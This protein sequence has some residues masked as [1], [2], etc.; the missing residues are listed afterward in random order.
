MTEIILM[1]IPLSL[2][3]QKGRAVDETNGTDEE[4]T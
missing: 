3:R 2:I 4:Q 1:C